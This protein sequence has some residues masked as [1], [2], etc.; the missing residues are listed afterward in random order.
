M[1]PDYPLSEPPK[2]FYIT[3]KSG[4]FPSFGYT[5]KGD[6]KKGGQVIKTLKNLGLSHGVTSDVIMNTKQNCELLW[7][8]KQYI[9]VFPV[10][11]PNGE[12]DSET[13]PSRILLKQNGECVILDENSDLA[14]DR[15]EF[16]GDRR[17]TSCIEAECEHLNMCRKIYWES[18]A[19]PI[20][21]EAPRLWTFADKSEKKEIPST[22]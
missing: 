12:P 17:G 3:L 13:D 5:I 16:K 14:G 15:L 4:K 9:V 1:Y 22:R 20:K 2:L 6:V 7:G 8:V 11:F 18:L 19:S 21:R 10:T